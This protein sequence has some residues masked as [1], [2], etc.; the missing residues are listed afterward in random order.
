MEEKSSFL[1]GKKHGLWVT[2]YRDGR[3]KSRGYYQNG[4]KTGKWKVFSKDNGKWY[5]NH[6]RWDDG[7]RTLIKIERVIE[8]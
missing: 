6:E 3:V 2:C 4:T 5:C 8:D 1:D 7:K